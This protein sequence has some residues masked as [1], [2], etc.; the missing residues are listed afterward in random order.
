MEELFTLGIIE[1][2][3]ARME[4]VSLYADDA[5][6]RGSEDW[7]EVHDLFVDVYEYDDN[8]LE[9]RL[10]E[11]AIWEVWSHVYRRRATGCY[12]VVEAFMTPGLATGSWLPTFRSIAASFKDVLS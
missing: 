9:D 4:H 11:D 6:E 8:G 5:L 1:S 10:R 2:A 3:N 7:Q 12:C